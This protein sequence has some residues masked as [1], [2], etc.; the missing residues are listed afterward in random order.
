MKSEPERQCDRRSRDDRELHCQ[1]ADHQPIVD[2]GVVKK[3]ADIRVCEGEADGIRS[4]LDHPPDTMEGVSM[5]RKRFADKVRRQRMEYSSPSKSA[6]GNTVRPGDQQNYGQFERISGAS[7]AG[8]K[9]CSRRPSNR[10]SYR[11][12]PAP[13]SGNTTTSAKSSAITTA[14]LIL[15]APSIAMFRLAITSECGEATNRKAISHADCHS[16]MLRNLSLVLLAAGLRAGTGPPPAQA[17]RGLNSVAPNW[18][19][20]RQPRIGLLGVVDGR[21]TGGR[22]NVED[23]RR[24]HT[25]GLSRVIVMCQAMVRNVLAVIGSG[26]QLLALL[27]GQARG[28]RAL[29]K[30]VCSSHRKSSSSII[31]TDISILEPVTQGDSNP[32]DHIGDLSQRSMILQRLYTCYFCFSS[33]SSVEEITASFPKNICSV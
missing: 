17:A 33:N 1:G 27:L 13:I 6:P 8:R 14:P 20:M 9:I 7:G 21:I 31:Y 5:D 32:P 22:D 23:H 19:R 18:H 30:G 4:R 26:W 3:R 28:A 25:F 12:S 2:F 11:A 15:A 29:Y 10:R 16:N 24:A